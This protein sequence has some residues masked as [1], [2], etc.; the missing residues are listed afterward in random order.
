MELL[1]HDFHDNI[2]GAGEC[3]VHASDDGLLDKP[4][5]ITSICFM[6]DWWGRS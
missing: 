2:V 6:V 1:L 3:G 4:N 5:K